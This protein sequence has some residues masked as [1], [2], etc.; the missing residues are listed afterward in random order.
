MNQWRNRYFQESLK[1]YPFGI[2]YCDRNA[3]GNERWLG[4]D[5]RIDFQVPY[6][7][8]MYRSLFVRE[9][10]VAKLLTNCLHATADMQLLRKGDSMQS[11]TAC[12]LNTILKFNSLTLSCNP[13]VCTYTLLFDQHIR[14]SLTRTLRVVT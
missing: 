9:I 3:T 12:R 5:P 11:A 10:L 7:G 4:V 6:Y 14:T 2:A 13:G 1:L 8:R